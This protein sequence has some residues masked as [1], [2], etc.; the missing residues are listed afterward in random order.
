MAS[1]TGRAVL[2]TLLVGIGL[3]PSLLLAVRAGTATSRI[4]AGSLRQS[5][6][7]ALGGA[8]VSVL[9]G[10]VCAVV[11]GTHDF[12][13]RRAATLLLAVPI[14]APPAFWWLGFSRLPN[15]T[16]PS[17]AAGLLPAS[18]VSGLSLSPVAFLVVLAAIRE[19][20]TSAYEAA[21]L[22]LS[23][24]LRLRW[25][26]VPLIKPSI[27]SAFLLTSILLLAESEIPFL[28]G[29]R[30]TMTDVIT[31]FSRTFD[32]SRIAAPAVALLLVVLVLGAS[33]ARPLLR[34]LLVLPRGGRGIARTR[35]ASA[36]F[37]AFGAVVVALS[38]LIGY[39]WPALRSHEADGRLSVN[40]ITVLVSICEPAL[41][42]LVALLLGVAAAYPLRR[43]SG[44]NILL[45]AGLLVFCIP[46]A[47]NAIGWIGLGQRLGGTSVPPVLVQVLRLWGMAAIGF[48][49]AYARLPKSLED[50]ARLIPTSAL[51]RTWTFV[52]P[53]LAPSLAATALLSAAIVYSDRD[54]V[55]LLLPPGAE[56]LTLD[57]YLASANAPASTVG[58]LGLLVFAAALATAGMASTIPFVV[59]RRRG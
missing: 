42:A 35:S 14:A 38:P 15:L 28:F 44:I 30:T 55:S 1:R 13:G 12:R 39:A 11:I 54:V 56:R 25:V 24:L 23:P 9:A 48:A 8:A 27:L 41:A 40:A 34:T 17:S 16:S 58:S 33:L 21:R 4:D 59:L 49:T 43:S 47:V 2:P 50:A 20:P 7:F 36:G 6:L 19:I 57:L 18:L 10:S 46:S 22:S 45:A 32:T 52:L 51:V 29:F 53:V 5:L 31:E 3:L 37:F 26:L